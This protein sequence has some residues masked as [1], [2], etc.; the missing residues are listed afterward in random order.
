MLEPLPLLPA[1]WH[2]V[3]RALRKLYI[4]LCLSF[5]ACGVVGLGFTISGHRAL[6]HDGPTP[7][8]RELARLR[9]FFCVLTVPAAALAVIAKIWVDSTAV[10]VLACVPLVSLLVADVA[11]WTMLGIALSTWAGSE[12]LIIEWWRARRVLM[13]LGVGVLVCLVELAV[14]DPIGYGVVVAW[15]CAVLASRQLLF[16]SYRTYVVFSRPLVPTGAGPA[17]PPPGPDDVSR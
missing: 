2:V 14:G 13:G 4:G 10:V 7:A 11:A 15:V 17:P 1:H 16:I 6:W 12:R 9:L 8:A 5:V 3:Y